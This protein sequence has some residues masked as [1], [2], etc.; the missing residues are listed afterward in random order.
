MLTREDLAAI[1]ARHSGL[2]DTRQLLDEIDHLNGKL[3]V[4]LIDRPETIR[5]IGEWEQ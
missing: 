4:D 1:S 3:F 5:M 2:G